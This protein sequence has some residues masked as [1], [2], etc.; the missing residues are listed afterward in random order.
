MYDRKVIPIG[1][2]IPQNSSITIYCGSSS[3]VRWM[4]TPFN[5]S[6]PHLPIYRRHRMV[7]KR[8]TLINVTRAD[9]GEYT[10]YGGLK[11]GQRFTYS[12]FINVFEV[13]PTGRVVPNWVEASRHSS[14]RLTCG[15]KNLVEWY[16]VHLHTQNKTFVGNTL[17]LFNLQQ[18]HSGRYICRG[19]FESKIFKKRIRIFHA[20]AIILVDSVIDRINELNT[21]YNI[22]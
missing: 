2:D 20:Q 18:E 13:T 12:T 1:P 15:S 14:I 8:V 5:Y 17:N 21:S 22:F 19:S 4:H 11:D 3:A 10:C 7:S 9:S 16:G 6:G